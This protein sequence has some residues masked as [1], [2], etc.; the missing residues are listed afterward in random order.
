MVHQLWGALTDALPDKYGS[1]LGAVFRKDRHRAA[2]FFFP[3][4]NISNS[5]TWFHNI[6]NT[7]LWTLVIF[8]KFLFDYFVVSYGLRAWLHAFDLPHQLDPDIE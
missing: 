3:Y 5:Q 1:K 6:M 4:G 8:I 7:L 2:D